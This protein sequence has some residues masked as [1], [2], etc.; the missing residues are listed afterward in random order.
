MMEDKKNFDKLGV[1]IGRGIGYAFSPITRLF[2]WWKSF[3]EPSRVIYFVMPDSV[4][5]FFLFL[6]PTYLIF[7]PLLDFYLNHG[8][9]IVGILL[10]SPFIFL[11]VLRIKN[12]QAIYLK[13]IFF[14]PY[15]YKRIATGC[16]F[17]LEEAWGD[18]SPTGVIFTMNENVVRLGS[19]N[20]ADALARAIGETLAI[21]GW[22]KR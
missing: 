15:W 14:V 10:V 22:W 8:K 21:Q 2:T 18:A 16:E 3:G 17:G 20:S 19:A 4:S 12:G 13:T 9:L 1:R 11:S 7:G 6:A 5:I